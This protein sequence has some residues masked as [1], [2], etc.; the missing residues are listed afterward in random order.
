MA[1]SGRAA[2]CAPAG[3][4]TC[5]SPRA[6]RRAGTTARCR[7][8]TCPTRTPTLTPA[9]WDAMP[10]PGGPGLPLLP[11]P[12][13]PG[14]SRF[15][16]S[17]AGATESLLDLAGLGRG[18]GR[19]SRWPRQLRA[20]VEALIVRRSGRRAR[21]LPGP[22]RRLLRAGRA[23][24]AVLAGFDG[25][26]EARQDID[27]L[28]RAGPGTQSPIRS[29]GNGGLTEL[30]FDCIDVRADPYAA[31]PSL[32][33]QLRI[34]ETTGV[35]V[36]AHRAAVPDQDR[37]ERRRYTPGRGRA[38]QR[39]VRRHRALGGD[40]QAA[41]VRQ[42]RGDGAEL[43]RRHRGRPV[44]SRCS[45]DLEIAA[46]SYFHA[47]DEDDIPLLLLFSGTIFTRRQPA[48]ALRQVPWRK[49]ATYRLPVTEWR[50]TM[51]A[52]F[53]NSGWLR[54]RL[55][56]LEALGAFKTARALPTWD[57]P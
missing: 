15:Y 40:P 51:D 38:A 28:L 21:V 44:P 37:A 9:Q 53:P 2:C 18:R 1:D 16:P 43:Y 5:C 27:G 24:P 11:A 12:I 36:H 48:S 32:G 47:L 13:S 41:S 19:Q 30:V 31:G 6:A 35:R 39:P 25:G 14:T 49:E 26:E 8:A 56:T 46:T 45:Y 17:P 52:F 3:P 54:L 42:R 20:D 4:A 55:D 57:L 7:I 29:T 34:A 22:D 10:V 33:F 50:A 23:D